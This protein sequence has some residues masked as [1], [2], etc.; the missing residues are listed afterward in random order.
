MCPDPRSMSQ[1]FRL[2][3]LSNGSGPLVEHE[4]TFL[5]GSW[6][7]SLYN[8]AILFITEA[9]LARLEPFVPDKYFFGTL[10]FLSFGTLFLR[11]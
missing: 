9:S 10:L 2:A 1:N 11:T 6:G 3:I 8:F 5:G 4:G 7:P